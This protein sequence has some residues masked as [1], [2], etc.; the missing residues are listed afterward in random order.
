MLKEKL[1]VRLPKENLDFVKYYAAE[2]HMTVTE[3]INRYLQQLR[4][5]NTDIDPAVEQI[6]GLI[7]KDIDT[8]TLYREYLLGKHQ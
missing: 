7:A 2:H 4:S 8:K 5:Q 3:I 1:T 6:S